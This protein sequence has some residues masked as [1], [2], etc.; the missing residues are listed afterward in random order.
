M[1]E[2]FVNFQFKNFSFQFEGQKARWKNRTF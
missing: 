2:N 1:Q